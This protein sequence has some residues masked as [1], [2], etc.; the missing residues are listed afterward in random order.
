MHRLP[1][2]LGQAAPSFCCALASAFKVKNTARSRN[3]TKVAGRANVGGV[4]VHVWATE[5]SPQAQLHWT[6]FGKH[7]TA[8]G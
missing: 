5:T 8:A 6:A 1:Q 4:V 2:L 3:V 7:T